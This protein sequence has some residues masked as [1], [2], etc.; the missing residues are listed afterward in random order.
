MTNECSGNACIHS[1]SA[2]LTLNLHFMQNRIINFPFNYNT[3]KV[4]EVNDLTGV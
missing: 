4:K 1:Y 3:L 2:T